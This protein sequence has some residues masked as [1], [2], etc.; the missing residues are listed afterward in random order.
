MSCLAT[1]KD[2]FFESFPWNKIYK[3]V[4]TLLINLLLANSNLDVS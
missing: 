2:G 3:R 1:V 4:Y